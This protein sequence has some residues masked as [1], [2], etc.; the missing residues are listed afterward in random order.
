[1][2]NCHFDGISRSFCRL[3]GE[4][5]WSRSRPRALSVRASGQI[6]VWFLELFL[7]AS[8]PE[9]KPAEHRPSIQWTPILA[10]S[11]L[12]SIAMQARP[13][14]IAE[15]SPLRLFHCRCCVSAASYLSSTRTD[16]LVSD[17]SR[18]TPVLCT[19]GT[20][21]VGSSSTFYVPPLPLTFLTSSVLFARAHPDIPSML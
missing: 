1:M 18:P 2:E 4:K 14:A 9:P 21:E 17:V 13:N 3:R 10:P 11:S 6:V 5:I 19:L 16:T 12:Y 20:A 8:N 7:A 15:T